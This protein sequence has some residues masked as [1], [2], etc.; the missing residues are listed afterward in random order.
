[1]LTDTLQA[2]SQA[3]DVEDVEYLRHGDLSLYARLYRPHGEGPF[4]AVVE[5]H[6]A[7]TPEQRTRLLS[8]LREHLATRQH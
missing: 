8:D 2:K 5:L 6:G 4:P 1:M 7:F 3:F